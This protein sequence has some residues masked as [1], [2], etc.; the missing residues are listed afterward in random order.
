MINKTIL[1]GATIHVSNLKVG[2]EVISTYMGGKYLGLIVLTE[3][4]RKAFLP[5]QKLGEHSTERG[6][7]VKMLKLV[8]ISAIPKYDRFYVPDYSV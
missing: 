6:L 8:P 7:G 4:N 5:M 2:M 1:L 3:T